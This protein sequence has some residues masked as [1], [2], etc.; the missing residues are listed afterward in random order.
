MGNIKLIVLCLIC[1]LLINMVIMLSAICN[2][3]PSI[4][5]GYVVLNQSLLESEDTVAKTD[6]TPDTDPASPNQEAM[7]DDAIDQQPDTAPSNDQP[8]D[9]GSLD[10]DTPSPDDSDEDDENDDPDDLTPKKATDK[11]KK[12]PRKPPKHPRPAP[13]I[14]VQ[15]PPAQPTQP[16]K[17]PKQTDTPTSNDLPF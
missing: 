6:S 4:D 3:Q 7:N 1:I 14:V 5:T 8:Q 12:H 17:P 16:V 10:F 13:A 2:N 11:T 15:Q 9:T